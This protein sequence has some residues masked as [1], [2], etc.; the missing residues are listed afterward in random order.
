[1]NISTQAKILRYKENCQ[2]TVNRAVSLLPFYLG[3]DNLQS[4]FK[5]LLQKTSS[6]FFAILCLL[7]VA[8]ASQAQQPATLS[9]EAVKRIEAIIESEK[10]KLNIPGLSQMLGG[11]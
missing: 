8:T 4:C 5:A 7:L 9:Q 6:A 3:V 10:A 11:A 1:M 2:S